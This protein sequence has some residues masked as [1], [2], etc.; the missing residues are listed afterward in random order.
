MSTQD[1][2]TR[3]LKQGDQ[4]EVTIDGRGERDL[5]FRDVVIRVDPHYVTEMHIDTDEANA[6][7][8]E[9]G[10][11]GELIPI[12]NCA[13]HVARCHTPAGGAE[14]SCCLNKPANKEAA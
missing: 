2:E 7:H 10:G 3:G 8:I 9:H 1:A 6:A 13:A 4:V 11:I 5:V 12:E 14:Q